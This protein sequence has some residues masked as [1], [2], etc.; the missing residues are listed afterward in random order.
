VTPAPSSMLGRVR[1]ARGLTLIEIMIS[2]AVMTMMVVSVW[3][4]FKGTLQGMETTEEAQKKYS[5][6][7]NG[8]SRLEAELTMTYL[9]QNRRVDDIK[10]Y[11]L[12]EGRDN[13]STDSLTFSAFAH[14]R[15]RKDAKESDQ[16]VIQ[17]FVEAD[18]EDSRRTHLYR[19]ETRR[20][21]GDLPE[22]LEQ[23]APAYVVIE[24][25]VEFELKYWDNRQREWLDE[26][27]TMKTDM[28][29]NRLPE[30]VWI[31]LVVKDFDGQL[32]EFNAQV[33]LMLQ[34]P[35]DLGKK[36]SG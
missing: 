12:F 31:K 32:T 10:H 19:R 1:S 5:I 33:V 20:L 21:T 27:R 29:P 26:W 8:L 22:Q 7:R 16:S 18:K 30:R 3:S 9:S 24:D 4:T 34:E 36:S 13:F 2:L 15:M 11:T 14:L 23:F 35:I 17:Y 28:H 6:I 25:V